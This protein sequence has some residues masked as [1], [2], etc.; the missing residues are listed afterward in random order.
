MSSAV[1][2]A[3]IYRGDFLESVHQGHAVIAHA[4]GEIVEVF[5]D[6]DQIILPRSSIKMMQALPLVESGAADALSQEH[7]ALACASHSGELRHVERVSRWLH[8]L[9]LDEHALC[10]GPEASRDKELRHAMI[11]D[12]QA[13]SRLHNN[14]SGKHAGF[15]TLAQKLK[16]SLDYVDPDNPVQKAVKAAIEEMCGEDSPGHGIDG[17]SAPNYALSLAGFARGLAQFASKTVDGVRGMATQRL[18]D[19]MMAHP[20]LVAGHGRA[21]TELMR[22]MP[23]KYVVK[24]GAEGVFSAIIPEMEIGI[25][26]KISD[27]ATRASEIAMAG[28]LVRVGALN[29]CHPTAARYLER[30]IRNWDG[31]LTG[32]ER[33][34]PQIM[35]R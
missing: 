20:G 31:L 4:S 12:S 9:G 28:L 24:T 3:E 1:P 5:G 17:C 2:M 22:A 10:C 32:Y 8:D 19:A 13:P 27:G 15:L 35:Q 6:P 7:L 34:S 16:A 23:G 11:R 33:A 21:C 29:A 26:V 14:C 25:A 18:R 30:S